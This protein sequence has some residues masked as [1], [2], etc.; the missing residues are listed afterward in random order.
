MFLIWAICLLIIVQKLAYIE[1]KKKKKL[2]EIQYILT[3]HFDE[4]D[5]SQT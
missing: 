4:Y 1:G 5:I 3:I 2:T